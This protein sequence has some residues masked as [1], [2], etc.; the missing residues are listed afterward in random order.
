MN[1][2]LEGLMIFSVGMVYGI[3]ISFL[4]WEMVRPGSEDR[5]SAAMLLVLMLGIGAAMGAIFY[6]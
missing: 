6:E 5:V 2:F 4:I 1:L 3:S